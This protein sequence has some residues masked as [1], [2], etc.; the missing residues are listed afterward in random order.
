LVLLCILI[1]K[2]PSASVKPLNQALLSI[3]ELS[4][5]SKLKLLILNNINLVVL[6]RIL[7][8]E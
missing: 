2:F 1:E 7:V 3:G 5:G 4:K 8:L 6:F